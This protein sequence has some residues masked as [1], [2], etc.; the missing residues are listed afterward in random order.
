MPN[1]FQYAPSFIGMYHTRFFNTFFRCLYRCSVVI[2]V[3]S[4]WL[5]HY[6]VTCVTLNVCLCVVRGLYSASEA[7][8]SATRNK[9]DREGC[10][11]WCRVPYWLVVPDRL[12]CCSGGCGHICLYLSWH[13]PSGSLCALLA[14]SLSQ[15]GLWTFIL[16]NTALVFSADVMYISLVCCMFLT[17]VTK[18]WRYRTL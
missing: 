17:V 8:D 7:R 18:K 1:R 4:V 5:L 2:F 11:T 15:V 14:Q 12:L 9:E 10:W 3:L 13:P 16:Q 6:V